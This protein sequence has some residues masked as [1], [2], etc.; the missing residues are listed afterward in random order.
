M[1]HIKNLFKLILY[2]SL[3]Y[4]R[5]LWLKITLYRG[6]QIF[7]C[8][9]NIFLYNDMMQFSMLR[10]QCAQK[11]LLIQKKST[12]DMWTDAHRICVNRLMYIT[13]IFYYY[14][15]SMLL[16]C[17]VSINCFRIVSNFLYALETHSLQMCANY[18]ELSAQ[19]YAF[20]GIEKPLD[21]INNR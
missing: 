15:I 13:Y 2:T 19:W 18:T 17:L 7:C 20:A 4:V 1:P 6:C 5:C 3:K 10:V 16:F 8:T 14:R 11:K 9:H 12:F 21:C